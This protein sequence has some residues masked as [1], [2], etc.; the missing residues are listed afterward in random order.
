MYEVFAREITSREEKKE[1]MLQLDETQEQIHPVGSTLR[2]ITKVM[3]RLGGEL[4]PV[5][6]E[7]I[8]MVFKEKFPN[9]Q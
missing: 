2:M 7:T 9:G 3:M 5:A 1:I 8:S 4:I 6:K